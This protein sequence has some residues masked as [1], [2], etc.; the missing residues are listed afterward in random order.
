MDYDRVYYLYL[1]INTS[2]DT[3]NCTSRHVYIMKGSD[4][5]D[6][7]ISHH[8]T[9]RITCGDDPSFVKCNHTSCR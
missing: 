8:Y 7:K 3:A 4:R 1:Y 2:H 6:V 9:P 5:S